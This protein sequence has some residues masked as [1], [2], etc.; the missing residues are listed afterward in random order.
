MATKIELNGTSDAFQI[1]IDGGTPTLI[2]IEEGQS[3]VYDDDPTK[4]KTS[5]PHGF[6]T[7]FAPD[8]ITELFGVNSVDAIDD[9]DDPFA[10][11]V[12][13]GVYL[14][15][16]LATGVEAM[17][18]EVATSGDY[19]PSAQVLQGFNSAGTRYASFLKIGQFVQVSL[20]AEMVA[21]A[22][23]NLIEVSC[24]VPDGLNFD[25]GPT[26]PVS[27]VVNAHGDTIGYV[28]GR[29]ALVG[30]T[31]IRF[32]FEPTVATGAS[33]NVSINATFGYRTSG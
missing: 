32:R 28:P 24:S 3:W 23:Q 19:T 2:Q 18:P 16:L 13:L 31:L 33:E 27:C 11:I 12:D 7:L 26:T 6:A 14:D 22:G 30:T 5:T 4:G 9:A 15:G 25:T 17:S 8:G 21:A 1:T 10:G 20:R 29:F